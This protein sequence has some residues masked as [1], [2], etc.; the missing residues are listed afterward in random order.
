MKLFRLIAVT[1][2]ITVAS[3]F[4]AF[5]GQWIKDNKGWW[6][7]YNKGWYPANKWAE[8][9]HGITSMLTAIWHQIPG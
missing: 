8:T 4:T 9:A 2:V 7:K 6:Y 5:A 1:A 3:S